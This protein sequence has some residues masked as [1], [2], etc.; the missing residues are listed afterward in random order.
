MVYKNDISHVRG[1]ISYGKIYGSGQRPSSQCFYRPVRQPLSWM[2]IT[3]HFG[4][5]TE[6]MDI[7][8]ENLQKC[9]TPTDDNGTVK[10]AGRNSR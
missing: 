9:P 6:G 3:Q 8:D 4:K 7:V 1:I 5:V 2:A 10:A